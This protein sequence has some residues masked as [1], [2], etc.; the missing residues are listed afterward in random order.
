MPSKSASLDNVRR[1]MMNHVINKI[2]LLGL[3][4]KYTEIIIFIYIVKVYD[5][6][7]GCVLN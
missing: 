5:V 4:V 7:I 3:K 6:T 1:S 2:A